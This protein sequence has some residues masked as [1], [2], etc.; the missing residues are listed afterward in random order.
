MLCQRSLKQES[1]SIV[2]VLVPNG[3]MLEDGERAKNIICGQAG[4]GKEKTPVT[5]KRRLQGDDLKPR[6]CI[7]TRARALS[8]RGKRGP[9]KQETPGS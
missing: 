6:C 4:K 5:T 1:C 2:K 9:R 8:N 3:M 7:A